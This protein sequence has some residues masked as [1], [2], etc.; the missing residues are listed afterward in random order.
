MSWVVRQGAALWIL[1]SACSDAGTEMSE[2]ATTSSAT[3][4]GTSS[5]SSPGSALPPGVCLGELNILDLDGMWCVDHFQY[6]EAGCASVPGC[7]W[8]AAGFCTGT[9][10]ACSRYSE[11]ECA[12][13]EYC[14][15]YGP[16][17]CTTDEECVSAWLITD[18]ACALVPEILGA[19]CDYGPRPIFIDYGVLCNDRPPQDPSTLCKQ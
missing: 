4:S 13:Q 14:E 8:N 9:P 2:A 12:A 7:T 16:P 6:D 18:G 3:A 19:S 15:W 1:C 10:T 11:A 5:A 17:R